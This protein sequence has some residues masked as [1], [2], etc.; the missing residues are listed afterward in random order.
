M[1]GGGA[2]TFAIGDLSRTGA[3]LVDISL[4]PLPITAGGD[5][6]AD[7]VTVAGTDKADALKLTGKVVVG[8]TATL[9]RPPVD[10][11]R[12]PRRGRSDTLAIA[13]GGGDGHARHLRVRRR[14]P[15]GARRSPD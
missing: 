1:L 6:A 9:D 11:Q 15:I 2:D 4:A 14:P 5:G 3:Q 8:G 7:R 12:L 13:G 10:G